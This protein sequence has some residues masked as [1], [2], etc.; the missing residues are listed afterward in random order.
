[1]AIGP[2][3]RPTLRGLRRRLSKQSP[4]AHSDRDLVLGRQ[5]P[6]QRLP[7]APGGQSA[8][9]EHREPG[10]LPQPSVW[11]G[12][13]QPGRSTSNPLF[14]ITFF[15]DRHPALGTPGR[16]WPAG[17]WPD[18]RP[19]LT[20]EALFSYNLRFSA[21]PKSQAAHDFSAKD[22]GQTQAGPG[23][24]LAVVAR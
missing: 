23:R 17:H 2:P 5:I 12:Q 20:G 4:T 14:S 15:S 21:A 16:G 9:P 13:P 3:V 8:Q 24:I 1:M 10:D 11:P 19:K 6:N 22:C 7:Q 18:P